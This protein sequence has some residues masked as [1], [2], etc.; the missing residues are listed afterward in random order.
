MHK[1]ESDKEVKK[2]MLDRMVRVGFGV[3]NKNHGSSY[4]DGDF[5]VRD[6]D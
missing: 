4:G 2:T 5:D 6:D 1:L 3:L